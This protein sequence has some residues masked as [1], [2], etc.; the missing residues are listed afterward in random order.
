MYSFK[1]IGLIA[2][3]SFAALVIG[4]STDTL[5]WTLFLATLI[6]IAI[7]NQQFLRVKKWSQQPWRK[8]ANGLDS[9]FNIAYQPHRTLL[10]ERRRTKQATSRL[11][12]ILDLVELIP[13]GIVV[14]T[15]HGVIEGLNKSA[16]RMLQLHDRDIGLSLPTVVRNP[17][18]VGFIN[19]VATG[20]ESEPLEFASSLNPDHTLEARKFSIEGGGLIILVRDITT[21]NRL[22]TVRQ[23]FVANVSH[24]LRT[25]LAV[26]QG[27]MES[28]ADPAEP[29]DLRLTLTS[30]LTSPL[31]RMQSLVDDLLL[32]TNLESTEP[33][34]NLA[35]IDLAAVTSQALKVLGEY[36]QADSRVVTHY[37]AKS[38]V[39][40]NPSEL[41]SLVVNLI[42]NALRYS[43][44]DAP[45]DVTI[46]CKDGR[47]RFTVAD[48]GVG[49]A[50]EHL[51]R[52][53]ER[54][55]RVDMAD[56]RTR[57]G[58]GLGLAI[59]KHVLRRHDSKL[60]IETKLGEGTT[61]W[62]EFSHAQQHIEPKG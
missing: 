20:Y 37:D 11:R 62:C 14:L 25:P 48:Q 31:N 27:Y 45:V 2:G 18:F 22:L 58:T 36:M 28:I 50:P 21:L 8:P 51:D 60:N 55:Y 33:E 38:L 35:A 34:E 29:T 1:E 54:F 6:W 32:L 3:L 23:N 17:N 52:L 49:I 26:I 59:V 15:N 44:D 46:S 24:E 30:K 57:G 53:T 19:T 16:T 12:Q 13:D 39:I 41:Q 43:H 42:T 5:G 40:G 4:I 56:S 61:F 47:V 7:Q 10:R 9:W